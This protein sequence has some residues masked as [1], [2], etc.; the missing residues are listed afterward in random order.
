MSAEQQVVLSKEWRRKARIT[1]LAVFHNKSVPSELRWTPVYTSVFDAQA[2][3]S[4][5]T[6]FENH[7]TEENKNRLLG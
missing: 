6:G 3:H 7:D 1:R 2:G 4:T 5:R